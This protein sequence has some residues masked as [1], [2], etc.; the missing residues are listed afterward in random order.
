MEKPHSEKAIWIVLATVFIDTIGF[1]IVIPVTPKLVAELTGAGLSEA[2]GYFGALL[3]T[4]SLLQFVFAPVMGNLADA[5]GRKPVL[6]ACLAAFGLDYIFMAVA[7][8]IG[9]LFVGRAIAGIAGASYVPASA[10]IADVTPP[11]QRTQR[12]G[13]L[14]AAWASGFIFGPV[15]GGVLGEWG[16]RLPFIAAALL[17]FA[18]LAAAVFVLRE[19]L[20]AGQRRPFDIRRAN[21]VGALRGI[22]RQPLLLGLLLVIICNQIAHDANPSSWTLYTMLK[23][24]WSASEVGWSLAATGVAIALVMSRVPGML[25]PRIGENRTIM[26]G[27]YGAILGYAGYAFA[28][29]GWMMYPLILIWSLMGLVGPALRAIMSRNA[30]ANAQGEL[31]GAIQSVGS[32]TAIASPLLMTQAFQFFTR[33]GA[34]IYFPGAPFLMASLFMAAGAIGCVRVMRRSVNAGAGNFV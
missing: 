16:A 11:D 33:N 31:Q 30:P 1:G 2:A 10:F 19:S 6:L 27:Y 29:Q 18:N 25:I 22:R 34:V 3:F 14:T 13:L 17:A 24:G 15:L 21:P 32:L 26:L 4:Y 23:F 9:W 28:S 5:I 7:P 20:P 12:F 8:T